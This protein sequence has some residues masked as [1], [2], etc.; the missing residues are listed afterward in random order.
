MQRVWTVGT[1]YYVIFLRV[2][3]DEIALHNGQM[4]NEKSMNDFFLLLFLA[5]HA[6]T[7][8][9]QSSFN[10][11]CIDLNTPF[12]CA[13]NENDLKMNNVC[14]WKFMDADM[15]QTTRV[16][17]SFH[18]ESIQIVILSGIA[19]A[20]IISLLQL[21][22]DFIAIRRKKYDR[23]AESFV[24]KS[25]YISLW[26]VR[27]YIRIAHVRKVLIFIA[28]NFVSFLFFSSSI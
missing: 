11:F 2:R 1:D 8:N 21:I 9:N 27:T 5:C 3:T 23:N 22:S 18:Y 28:Q 20:C 24:W 14:A 10:T 25:I 6:K 19:V 16:S 7:T 12:E 15:A 13:A 4:H 17:F 26:T